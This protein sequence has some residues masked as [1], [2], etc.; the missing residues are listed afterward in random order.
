MTDGCTRFQKNTRHRADRNVCAYSGNI[1]T[2]TNA[3]SS[4]SILPFSRKTIDSLS[5]MGWDANRAAWSYPAYE[6]QAATEAFGW[7]HTLKQRL[8]KQL[9][10]F[11]LCSAL[12]IHD[13]QAYDTGP[14]IARGAFDKTFH[15]AAFHQNGGRFYGQP[16]RLLPCQQPA[17]S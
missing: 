13:A 5:L 8:Q 17:R 15:L 16:Q 2:S 7:S 6:Q 10:V 12:Q 4:T 9:G 11:H 14:G 3:P 1:S